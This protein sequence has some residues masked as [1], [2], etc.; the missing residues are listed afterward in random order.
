MRTVQEESG[1]HLERTG[2]RPVS[3]GDR[4]YGFFDLFWNWFG[5]GANASSW[6]FGGLL[7][8]SGVS[9]L[10]WNT[11]FWTPL[12]ILPWATLAYMAY[13]TGG[14]TVVLARPALGVTGGSL[15]LG[16]AETVVQ[17]GWTTVTTYIGAVSLVQIWNG[18]EGT[19]DP[20]SG[21]AALIFPVALIA[22][23]QG[24][25]ATLGPKAIRILKWIA[26]LLLLGFGGV[27]TYEVLSRWDLSRILSYGKSAPVFTPMQL[28]DISFINIWTWLQV[29]DF[30]RLSKN[31][32][33]AV[34]ASWL[35]I[36]S[37]QAWFVLV[38][39]VGVIG[40][41]LATGHSSPQDSDP[42][43]LMGHLGLSGVALSVIFLSSVSVSSSNL[44]GAGM[45]FD[46]LWTG[47]GKTPHSRKAL[48]VVSLIQIVTSFLPLFFAS[49]ISY[50]TSFLSTIGGIFIP[51]WSLVLT[52]YLWYRKR[53]LDV[54]SL[55]DLSPGSRY[56]G[57]GGFHPPGFL[58]LGLGIAFYYLFPRMA[59]AVVQSVGVTFPTIL[60][61]GGVYFLSLRWRGEEQ[62]CRIKLPADEGEENG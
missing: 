62:L 20:S 44:Y 46:A 61:T 58:A 27:E 36:W 56:W 32:R 30:A 38:G 31:P 1:Q 14:T 55:Y 5:D 6:Y 15:F 47:S 29:G 23:L 51:L 16:V 19:A 40:L 37:G 60:W 26:S 8:L 33:V 24:A 49:F 41:G 17:I 48:G 35:G 7:A 21:K 13:R 59:P 28:L 3:P 22:L 2:I 57:R 12:I 10:F 42:A 11:F 39:A 34:W 25:V 52:D 4:T 18:G 53:Q 9:I 54:P 50:F 43:R 45:A